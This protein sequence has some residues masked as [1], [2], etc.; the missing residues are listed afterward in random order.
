MLLIDDGM[1]HMQEAEQLLVDIQRL[2]ERQREACR[3]L[4]ERHVDFQSQLRFVKDR[5]PHSDEDLDFCREGGEMELHTIIEFFN[6]LIHTTN[7]SR[8]R[9]WFERNKIITSLR[10]LNE[11]YSRGIAHIHTF[12]PESH[13]LF[14]PPPSPQTALDPDSTSPAHEYDL[15]DSKEP[16]FSGEPRSGGGHSDSLAKPGVK[17]P[18]LYNS[19][20]SGTVGLQDWGSSIAGSSMQ[21]GYVG[22][23]DNSKARE[24]K[25]ARDDGLQNAYKQ[26]VEPISQQPTAKHGINILCIGKLD[27]GGIRGLSSLLL[28]KEVMARLQNLEGQ[29]TE[30]V[31][32]ADWFDVIAGTGTGGIIGCMLGKLGMSI[33]EAIESYTKLT[34]A[35]FSS[36]QRGGISVASTRKSTE[37]KEF[38][39]S[40]V[41]D[42]T[43]RR[44][45]KIMTERMSKSGVCN[46]I[47]FAMSKHNINASTPILFRSYLPKA[48]RAP[49]C[50]IWEALYATMAHPD[51]FKSIEIAE[52]SV[53]YSFIGG[54][55]GNSNPIA[56]LLTE[57]R[58]L[59][60][61][62]HVSCI[63]SIGAGHA[64]TIQIPD[65]GRHP[66]SFAMR[67]MATDSERVAEEMARRF[68]ETRGVYFRFNVDQGIQDVEADDWEKLSIVGAHTRA[69]MNKFE[70]NRGMHEAVKAIHCRNAAL[71]VGCID[72][73]VLHNQELAIIKNCPIPSA[74][75]TGR[76][77]ESQRIGACIVNSSNQQ[78]VCVI[79]GLG[80]AG[81]SQLAFKAVE[82][83]H[84]HWSHI[85]YVDATSRETIEG[86]LRNFAK[87]KRFGTTY[88]DTLQWLQGTKDSW[89]LVFD[90]ADEL[91]LDILPYFPS[92]YHGSILIT[93]RLEART[94]L[95][96]PPESVHHVSSMDLGDAT[97]LLLRVVH[98]RDPHQSHKP[99]DKTDANDLV[100]D[101]G[102]LALAIVHAGA[103]IA[104]SIGMSIS[105]Y[106][107][108]FLKRRQQ[109]LERY[110]TLPKSSKFDDYGKTVYTT[111]NMCYELLE[112]RGKHNAQELLWL[113]AFLHHDGLTKAMFQ[114]ATTNI[115]RYA[116]A[117]PMSRLEKDAY[118]YLH[119]YLL[120]SV[121][122]NDVDNIEGW[123][124][125]SFMEIISELAAYSLVE[126]DRANSSYNI[127][128]LVQ[129][130]ARTIVPHER[131]I[132]LERTASLVAISIGLKDD[133]TS[134]AFRIGLG[135]HVIKILSESSNLYRED[136]G[137]WA[138]NP[139]HAACFANVFKA[140][141]LWREEERLRVLVRDS[142]EKEL[143]P[144]DPI[145]LQSLDDLAHNYRNQGQMDAAE[146]MYNEVLE[147]RRRLYWNTHGEEHDN[148]QASKTY[149]A[150]LYQYQGRLREALSFWEDV[151][152][153]YKISKG[154][155]HSE[156]LACMSNLADTYCGLKQ[157]DKAEDLRKHI[158]DLMPDSHSDKPVCVR[159]LSEI[160]ELQEKWEAAE[161]LLIGSR[162][163]LNIQWG[164]RHP[165]AIES[166]QH[167]HDFRLRRLS[168]P[169][170]HNDCP[171][172]SSMSL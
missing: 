57:V 131:D 166:Q 47:V 148:I 50:T 96:K 152:Q 149:L 8:P 39:Q 128:V 84:H 150:S 88:T 103:Y 105:D 136:S 53:N 104:H 1:E 45:T 55:L 142:R 33:E 10:A 62:R 132:S 159:K 13:A 7:I 79:H 42:A 89:L 9:S 44:D 65:S 3:D 23:S 117:F 120:Q 61:G 110:K 94:G 125:S 4:Y 85:I 92:C 121:G 24:G 16:S 99:S 43:G 102:C 172:S 143:G 169:P 82:Q 138:V 161:K 41:R 95:A 40:I 135:Q 76:V 151:V 30:P 124:E 170:K 171:S 52:N 46:T 130:W 119:R 167:L 129:D 80:G 163:V 144:E 108:M 160:L 67:A 59:Y 38:L 114:Y 109:T 60:P 68:Q 34:E 100:R 74:Y 162:E 29:G 158:L 78:R 15:V 90:G 49:D 146:S 12:L 156:T 32:P 14:Q 81:K 107:K 133:P 69:Y 153:G 165:N 118:I 139:N 77:K 155:N 56:H 26:V 91:D 20:V 98:R 106:R 164:E 36:K 127:H 83:N 54:E 18:P 22:D 31:N 70:V 6:L 75:Y 97:S 72:G 25:D 21:A 112:H 64:H 27:G 147:V 51:F 19:D 93:T 37:L 48:N 168:L 101:F 58:E 123:A 2:C 11:A 137:H 115:S 17:E 71:A 141:G 116:P 63:L 111:W 157:L 113:I 66:V 28:L 122:P 145:T 86:T 140:M 154:G 87:A 35:A 73:R 126:Y 5:K 134:R